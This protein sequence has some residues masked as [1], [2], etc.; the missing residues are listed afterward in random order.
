MEPE[1]S[2]LACKLDWESAFCCD[3]T[4]ESIWISTTTSRRSQSSVSVLIGMLCVTE[5]HQGGT[6]PFAR[7]W[8]PHLVLSFTWKPSL[9]DSHWIDF[10]ALANAHT[11]TLYLFWLNWKS[12][13]KQRGEDAKTAARSAQEE[14]QKNKKN[15]G[16]TWGQKEIKNLKSCMSLHVLRSL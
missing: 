3:R 1:V 11:A 10:F 9:I 13:L 5:F 7:S 6:P 12:I 14:E 15:R 8:F 16:A 4:G 2:L